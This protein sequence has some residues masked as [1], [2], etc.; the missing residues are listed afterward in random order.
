MSIKG[1]VVP[2]YASTSRSAN[3]IKPHI[4]AHPSWLLELCVFI[5]ANGEECWDQ[6]DP[7]V[8]YHQLSAAELIQRIY[9]ADIASLGTNFFTA[10]KLQIGISSL[11][12]LIL[13]AAECKPYI[14]AADRL[15]QEDA[16][17]IIEGTQILCHVICNQR[18]P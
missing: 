13:N 18:S 5:K 17:Q 7:V 3:A 14:I 12:T 10:S 2:V 16:D 1:H 15:V 8:N 9:Q 6:S 11:E 4:T